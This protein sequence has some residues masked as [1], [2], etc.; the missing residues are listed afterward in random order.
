ME[1]GHKGIEDWF[2]RFKTV[3]EYTLMDM[4]RANHMS[5]TTGYTLF[6]HG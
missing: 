5:N 3:G 6:G 4:R 2:N 1:L